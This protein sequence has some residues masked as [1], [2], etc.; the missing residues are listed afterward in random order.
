MYPEIFNALVTGKYA[1]NQIYI[2]KGDKFV[3]PLKVIKVV[4][5]HSVSCRCRSATF[6]QRQCRTATGYSPQ[7]FCVSKQEKTGVTNR[8]IADIINNITE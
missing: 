2:Y 8:I 5:Q 7:H 4:C 1:L 3:F 6:E